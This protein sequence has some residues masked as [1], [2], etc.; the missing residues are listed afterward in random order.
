MII[1]TV[2][3][4]KNQCRMIGDLIIKKFKSLAN[5]TLY[6]ASIID[7]EVSLGQ[8]HYYEVN[9]RSV[10]NFDHANPRYYKI[11]LGMNHFDRNKKLVIE[12]I[13]EMQNI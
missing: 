7:I 3:F 6:L 9:L 8:Y 4:N 11:R 10:N 13:E 1:Q 5:D 2:F 12:S